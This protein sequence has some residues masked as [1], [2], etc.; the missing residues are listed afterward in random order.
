[1]SKHTPGPWT[2]KPPFGMEGMYHT[3][4]R[5]GNSADFVARVD[6]RAVGKDYEAAEK[7]CLNRARLIAA[8]PDLLEAAKGFL[9]PSHTPETWEVWKKKLEAAIAKA[10]EPTL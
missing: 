9:A 2:F 6:S 4:I 3:F 10:E 8:A 5:E 7:L 1:M